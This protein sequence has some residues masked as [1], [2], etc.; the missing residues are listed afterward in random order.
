MVN[1]GQKASQ[2]IC[3]AC[4]SSS[5]KWQGQCP[6][7]G[8]W[9]TL[10]ETSKP[11]GRNNGAASRGV[12][13]AVTLSEILPSAVARI[14]TGS[15]EFDRVLG[16]GL[17]PGSSAVLGGFPGAGKSTLLLQAACAVADI[18]PVV[19]VAGEEALEQVAARAERLG[20]PVGK[21][22]VTDACDVHVIASIVEK[23]KPRFVVIDSIQVMIHPEVD[24]AAG[25]VSQV[26]E[27]ALFLSRLAKR[28]QAAIVM[29]GHIT[30]SES[31]AGP[32]TLN[33]LVDATLMLSS[34][35]DSRF[36]F[37][38]ADKNRFGSVNELAVFAMAPTGMKD[39]KNPSAMFLNR[40]ATDSPGSVVTVL[41]EGTRP[42]LV[43]VQALADDS[44]AGNARRVSVGIDGTRLSMLLAVLHRHGGDVVHDKDV[45]LNVVG[46]VR[47]SETAADLAVVLAVHSSFRDSPI[48]AHVL[49][50]GEVGLAGEIRPC[51]NGQDRL[52][53]AAKHGFK[54]AIVPKANAPKEGIPGIELVPVSSLK[55]ALE[56]L[57]NLDP[58]NG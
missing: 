35:D 3:S 30:K 17:V 11:R 46:G 53:E 38:R 44:A 54:L 50:F 23:K 25:S 31:L 52:R 39:V 28:M 16:G 40:I 12:S 24:S 2:W 34:S 9:N 51:A 20:L 32:M 37:I 1:T 7:C 41:W 18:Y 14:S 6:S 55:E 56:A 26:R 33:H 27:T 13:E 49:A 43:E 19:Y 10:I 29:V 5:P 22:F 57:E 4:S 45:F 42:L 58:Q 21:L 36:R 47:V 15:S 8:A 48:P